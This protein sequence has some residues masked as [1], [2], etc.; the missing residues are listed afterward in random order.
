[1]NATK[2]ATMI[3]AAEVMTRPVDPSPS[4]T[5]RALPPCRWYDCRTAVSRNT[6]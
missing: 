3:S 2:T 6:S 1:M 5:A 4:A